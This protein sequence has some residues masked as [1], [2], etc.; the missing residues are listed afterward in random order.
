MLAYSSL[1]KIVNDGPQIPCVPAIILARNIIQGKLQLSG[2]MPCVG[3]IS[4]HDYLHE[5]KD[6][7]I[8]QHHKL[9]QKFESHK[10]E[11]R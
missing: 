11:L 8:T 5:L 10:N 9:Q 2:A 6:F 7:A 3:M 4:L 1:N